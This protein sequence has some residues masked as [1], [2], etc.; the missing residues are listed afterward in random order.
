MIGRVLPRGKN[1]RGV[2]H[3]LF[4]KGK[5]N[6]HVNPHLVAGWLHPAGLE[7]PRRADGNRNFNRL[8]GQL[9][10]PV[11]LARGKVADEF[12]YHLVLRCAPEDPDLGDGAWNAIATEV[13]HRTGLSERGREDQGVQLDSGSPRREPHPHRGHPRRPGPQAR[14]AAQRLLPDRRGAARHRARVRAAR[15]GP[16]GPDRRRNR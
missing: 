11:Q 5:Q 16:G 3:Y 9:E 15:A 10:L 8:T 4:G 12:V 13:M 2:L 1:V 14:V 6:Q 7:P